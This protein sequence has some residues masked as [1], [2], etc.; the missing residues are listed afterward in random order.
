MV[1]S[2]VGVGTTFE[3]YLPASDRREAMAE[4]A[5]ET[6]PA[7]KGRVLVMDDEEMIREL[8]GDM[9]AD[10]GYEVGFAADGAEAI[11][12]YTK[13]R[14]SGHPYDALVID[15]TIP[16]AMG[17]RE[18]ITRLRELDPRVRAIVSSGYATDAVM[19]E[20]SDHG[21]CACVAKPYR[22]E[23]LGDALHRAMAGGG[24]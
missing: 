23:E 22:I 1:E 18:A 11:D 14:E 10:L 12:L 9:L 5:E 16:G 17:G 3:L 13:A 15:L 2:E 19:T 6:A 21:F 7:G 4:K 8:T 24:E 20:F